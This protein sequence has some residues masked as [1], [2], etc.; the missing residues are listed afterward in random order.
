VNLTR[1]MA[2]GM[3]AEH[4]PMHGHQIRRLAEVTNVGE[5][6]G[7]S[8]GALYRELRTMEGEGVIEAV[9]TE[10]VGRRPARTVY[11]ITSEGEL[12]LQSLRAQALAV[13][14][15]G[16]DPVGVALTFT[17][18]DADPGELRELLK[19]RQDEIAVR[20]RALAARRERLIAAGHLSPMQAA[21]MRRGV[22]QMRADIEWHDEIDKIIAGLPG[23]DA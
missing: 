16:A 7:V 18:Q 10:Q 20:M 2:L 14:W 17:V 13:T 22:L 1:L 3:L 11:A 5:W 12:E 19:S 9:R 15:W 4:G 21:V 8:V 23:E 6:G